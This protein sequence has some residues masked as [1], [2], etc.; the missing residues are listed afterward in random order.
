MI[1]AKI[2]NIRY[3][4]L[5]EKPLSQKVIENALRELDL[6]L[7]KEVRLIMGGGGAM[8]MA[9]H[10]PLATSDVDAIPLNMPIDELDVLVKRVAKKLSLPP[11]WL[12]PYFSTFSHV[13]PLDYGSRLVTVFKGQNLFVDAIGKEDLLIMKCFAHRRKDVGHAKALIKL[14]ANI[15][16]VENRI[17]ELANRK[18]KGA[19]EAFDFLDEVLEGE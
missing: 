3:N 13:L 15:E 10:Y 12:N 14:G 7:P 6:I 5:M 17:Q 9:H 19:N 18:I 8:I 1:I 11:D 2:N 4:R 16:L